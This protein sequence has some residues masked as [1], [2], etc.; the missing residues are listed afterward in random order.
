MRP[1]PK[2]RLK[3]IGAAL[4]TIW[5]KQQIEDLPQRMKD[6]REQLA[7]RVLASLNTHYALQI[8]DIQAS[9]AEVMEAI[10]LNTASV[11]AVL[12][13]RDMIHQIQSLRLTRLSG[14]IPDQ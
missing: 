12:H 14:R 4:K 7:F 6:L 9:K 13:L 10:S 2:K 5:S 1:K 8:N 3:S 11:Q